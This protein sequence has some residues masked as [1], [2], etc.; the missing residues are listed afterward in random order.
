M[1]NS[2]KSKK[3]ALKKS[4]RKKAK[5]EYRKG[6]GRVS[7]TKIIIVSTI[8]IIAIVVL[9][10]VSIYNMPEPYVNMVEKDQIYA[11]FDGNTISINHLNNYFYL[12]PKYQSINPIIIDYFP[13]QY[14][15]T[16][17]SSTINYY[18]TSTSIQFI[19][20]EEIKRNNEISWAY[21][22][23][24][25]DRNLNTWM[26]LTDIQVSPNILQNNTET[27]VNITIRFRAM[28]TIDYCSIKIGFKNS[29]ETSNGK[30]SINPISAGYK[31][32]D[33]GFY[34]EKISEPLLK[35]YD[36]SIKFKINVTLQSNNNIDILNATD[37]MEYRQI[38]LRINDK[39][40]NN[41]FTDGFSQSQIS[42]T[43]V[44]EPPQLRRSKYFEIFLKIANISFSVI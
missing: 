34:Y 37:L 35:N 15:P 6:S 31:S 43:G 11:E 26:S 9:T 22:L 40:I 42:F 19:P 25:T 5:R 7:W 8:I 2:I 39:L 33:S 27:T 38:Y 13:S 10:F 32:F 29:V 14:Y 30:A 18:L 41:Y 1:P 44:D 36:F 28:T 4:Y 21:T 16:F 23:N 12:A 24:I 17:S 3:K 20:K